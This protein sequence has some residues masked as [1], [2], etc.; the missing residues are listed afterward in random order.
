M[1]PYFGGCRTT[2]CVSI[3]YSYYT[4]DNNKRWI[5]KELLPTSC[6]D[7]LYRPCYWDVY[8][9]GKLSRYLINSENTL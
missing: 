5:S 4:F 2:S 1:D 7:V 3:M 8:Q 9:Y 6:R